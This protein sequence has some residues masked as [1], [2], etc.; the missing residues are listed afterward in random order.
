[1]LI[2]GGS[3]SASSI[4]FYYLIRSPMVC[5]SWSPERPGAT[6]TSSQR[7]LIYT[8]PYR[9]L[10]GLWLGDDHSNR[11]HMRLS[12]ERQ[13]STENSCVHWKTVLV[14]MPKLLSKMSVFPCFPYERWK[15]IILKGNHR[16]QTVFFLNLPLLDHS[17]SFLIRK[18]LVIKNLWMFGGSIGHQSA[19]ISLDKP[20]TIQGVISID[21]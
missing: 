3:L 12:T 14:G 5:W 1:M 19:N 7:T 17:H 8:R 10:V 6:G 16:L 4:N 21:H 9:C 13:L 15:T 2:I 11:P 18:D 20:L